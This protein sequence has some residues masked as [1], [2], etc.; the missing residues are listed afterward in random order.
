[1]SDVS[2]TVRT[3]PKQPVSVQSIVILRR[4]SPVGADGFCIINIQSRFVFGSAS[5][6]QHITS[7]VGFAL[8]A[9]RNL[10]KS[11]TV[12]IN[13]SHWSK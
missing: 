6:A 8:F 13:Y 5:H 10:E 1:M 11:L 9:A 3:N 4:W 7:F 2:P 12:A